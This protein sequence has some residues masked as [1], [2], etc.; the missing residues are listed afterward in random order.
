MNDP[1]SN[2]GDLQVPYSQEA[3]EATIGAVLVDASKYIMVSDF[4]RAEDFFIL[5]HRYIW[6][7]FQK[8]DERGEPID[9][10][11][12]TA[13]LKAAGRLSEIGGPAYLTQLINATPT[14]VHG[15]TY[16][17]LVE[18]AAIRRR[19]MVAG[20]EIKALA[21]NEE[22][23]V[24]DVVGRAQQTII[25]VTNKYEQGGEVSFFDS[26]SEYFDVVE[27]LMDSDD[28][29]VGTPSG[30][31]DFDNLT[32]GF[33]SPDLLIFAGRPGMGKS[34]FLLSLTMNRLRS[35]PNANIGWF[36]LEMS[37]KQMTQRAVSLESGI[38]IQ[39]L[40]NGKL[41]PREW[42]KFVSKTGE[43]SQ[44][45]L[46]IDD[47]PRLT[48]AQVR[49]KIY[50]WTSR[51]GKL[52]YVVIDYLQLMTG[53]KRFGNREQEISYI[54]EELKNMAKEFD[55]PVLAAAQLSRS[56]EQRQD[57]RPILSDL[58]ESGGIE[59]N[60][61]L[62][63]FLYRDEVYNEAT[64]FPNQADIIVAKHRNGPTGTI[65]LYFEKT[66]T[67]FMNSAERSVDLSHI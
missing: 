23:V 42:S 12:V 11:T 61:D 53:G 54:S 6:E 41:T 21:L 15:E 32:L 8:L 52:D 10:L 45:K 2:Q 51:H 40:K 39:T 18:R 47:R 29:I 63:V 5:R 35:D 57:K 13:Q 49:S 43:I 31:N 7:S 38:N 65:S 20:D 55:I 16:A 44:Y 19:L 14:S 22:M 33:Q 50:Q 1:N 26:V 27:N 30:F 25:D 58:R 66:L 36:P 62:V 64:E 67:K 48:P 24:D 46:H 9:Y 60:A 3:E 4:L 28:K 59:N 17:H 37:R 34:S 56:V